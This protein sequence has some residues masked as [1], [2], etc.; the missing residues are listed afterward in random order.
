VSRSS[1]GFSLLEIVVAIAVLLIFL[2]GLYSGIQMVF[3]VV[4]QSRI[5]VLE[6]GLLNEQIE[7]IRNLPFEDIGIVNGSPAGVLARTVT[8]TRNGLE[9]EITRTIRNIDDPFD[10]TIGGTPNDT[11]PADYKAVYVEVSCAACRQEKPVSA[12]TYVA[13]KYLEGDPTHGALFIQVFDASAQPVS[14]AT[15]RVVATTTDPQIDLED[16]TDNEGMLRLVDL[17]GG[18]EAYHITVTKAGY[19]TD[20]TYIATESNPNPVRPPA[21]VVAQDVTEISFSIDEAS[22][23]SITTQNSLCSAVGSVP[24][25]IT[26]TRIIGTDPSVPLTDISITTGANGTY[27]LQSY[28]WDTYSLETTSYDIKGAIPAVP[29]AISPGVSQP[30]QLMVG[31]DSGISLLTVVRDAITSQ[32][33]SNATVHVTSVAG[34]DKTIVTDVGTVRQTDWSGGSGQAEFTNDIRYWSA[35]GGVDTISSA[36]NITLSSVGGGTYNLSGELESSTID[37]GLAASYVNLLWEPLAQPLETGEQSVRFQLASSASSSPAAWDFVGP[38][39]TATSYYSS[40]N[41]VIGNHHDG[42][43]YVRYKLFLETAS[44][45]YTPLVSDINI[46]YTNSCTPPGQAYFRALTADEYTVSVTATG[47]Q[48]YTS[49]V[50]VSDDTIF[51][52][53]MSTE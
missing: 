11:A 21:T 5:Q 53:Q 29:I 34:Y 30:I 7:L 3:K 45:T 25:D 20:Q 16:T 47:Y 1:K 8:T 49:T 13:P 51:T 9:F 19:T 38:D 50:S 31:A 46:T 48:P 42:N 36:G 4:Y 35:T 43:Q 18:Q 39:G 28:P 37:L 32:P 44:S 24:I 40:T 12:S 23:L 10:G 14:G 33:V 41:T 27:S 52:I 2:V 22:T 15:V 17:P 6:N 26:G